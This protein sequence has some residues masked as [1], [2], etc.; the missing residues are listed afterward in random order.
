[1][2]V[3]VVSGV[4]EHESGMVLAVFDSIEKAEFAKNHNSKN[5]WNSLFDS[6]EIEEFEVQ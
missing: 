3:Y 4:V 5:V 2:K 6:I 1:M